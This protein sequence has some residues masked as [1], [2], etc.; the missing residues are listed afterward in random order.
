M[1]MRFNSILSSRL[2]YTN[3]NNFKARMSLVYDTIKTRWPFPSIG[4][5]FVHTILMLPIRQYRTE[6]VVLSPTSADK[7]E[8]STA[9]V[10]LTRNF[11]ACGYGSHWS[12]PFW[13]SMLVL[14]NPRFPV[15]FAI[16]SLVLLSL[17]DKRRLDFFRPTSQS[18]FNP[19]PHY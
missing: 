4:T 12:R 17:H 10:S 16:K 11:R 9:L 8:R 15:S 19:W 7:D 1:T 2:R 5:P 3:Q 6:H 13:F 14:C 18:S